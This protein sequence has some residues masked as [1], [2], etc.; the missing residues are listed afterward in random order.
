MNAKYGA[1]DTVDNVTGIVNIVVAC[2]KWCAKHREVWTTKCTWSGMCDGCPECSG[3]IL[4]H[5]VDTLFSVPGH[6]TRLTHNSPLN[7][8]EVSKKW[9]ASHKQGWDVKCGWSSCN[10]CSQCPGESI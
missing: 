7:I 1:Y 10:G 8:V 3:E 6:F 9:C 2:K 4:L 5:F